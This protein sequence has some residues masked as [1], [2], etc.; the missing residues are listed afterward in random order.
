MKKAIRVGFN[1]YYTEDEFKKHIAYVKENIDVIDE[2]TMFT[3]FSHYGYWDI[4]TEA[5]TA[6][7]AKERIKSYR[8]AG[9]KS[10]GL[11]LL[12][13]IGHIEEGWG[14]FPASPL[15]LKVSE[16]GIES[17][18]CLCPGNDAFLEHTRKRYALFA[19]TGADFI[20]IDD[21]L[22]LCDHGVAK[23]YCYCEDCIASFNKLKGTSYKR[24]E[25]VSLVHNSPDFE[26]EWE[27]FHADILVKVFEVIEEGVHGVN[28]EVQIGYMSIPSNSRTDWIIKSGAKKLRPGD[29]FYTD[30]HPMNLFTKCYTL[31][32]QIK[33]TPEYITDIQYEYEAFNYQTMEKSEHV[34]ELE[35]TL[36]L[37]SGCNGA[38]YNDNLFFDRISTTD[39]LRRCRGRME[40]ITRNNENCTPC[41]V[42]CKDNTVARMFNEIGVPITRYK[43]NAV[44]EIVTGADIKKLSDGEIEALGSVNILTDGEGVEILNERGFG[45]IICGSVKKRYDNGMAERFSDNELNGG[46]KN[47]YRDIFMNF[48]REHGNPDAY[49]LEPCEGAVVLSRLETITHIPGDTSMYIKED[50]GRRVAADGYLIP[51][52][53]KSAPKREQLL[54]VL[55]WVSHNKLPIMTDKAVKVM[56]TV[57]T[58]KNGGM[59]IMLVNASFDATGVIRCT[60]RNDKDF[61]IISEDGTPVKPNQTHNPGET[62]VMID[63]IPAW[64]YL[65]MT[66]KL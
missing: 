14:V 41:G 35:T 6:A 2:I 18:S 34:S 59:N 64:G 63:N 44:M 47:H 53:I 9:V 51:P 8:A 12:V 36:A 54:N 42:Y 23:K 57:T 33:N 39:M 10:V 21:D 65:V 3:E 45:N 13:T 30:E 17:K 43:E 22:R 7:V 52:A 40:L 38:L 37:M 50:G 32:D 60:V 48:K 55:D 49:E 11:N 19:A 25:I 24:E 62:V 29:G 46:Y 31:Q 20:W 4:E 58:D 61:Y 28:P 16:E 15:R 1:Q 5:K 27:A 66:N 26:R 56:P